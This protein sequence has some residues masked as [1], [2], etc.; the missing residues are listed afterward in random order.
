MFTDK[1]LLYGSAGVGK[2]C[3]MKVVAGEKP[4]DVRDSTPVAT[5]PV[6]M[7][8]LQKLG[9]KWRKYVSKDKMNL[10]AR[11]SKTTL[12]RE[13]IEALRKSQSEEEVAAQ[14]TPGQEVEVDGGSEQKTP[15]AATRQQPAMDATRKRENP[16]CPTVPL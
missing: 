3:T 8:Q 14:Q 7:Y 11:I 12:G 10:C 9:S 6:T 15:T 16:D 13:I 2:T 5:R 4:P 1:M